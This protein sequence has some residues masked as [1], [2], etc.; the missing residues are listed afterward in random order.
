M[1]EGY[2]G[3]EWVAH[4]L[5][6]YTKMNFVYTQEGKTQI[7]TTQTIKNFEA[8]VKRQ[9]NRDIQIFRIA[10]ESSLGGIFDNWVRRKGFKVKNSALYAPAQN[11]SAEHSGATLIRRAQAILIEAG[12]PENI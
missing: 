12:L 5:D 6:D 2:D 10:N 11:G 3:S 9:Y 1:T 4:F 8:F 7:Q